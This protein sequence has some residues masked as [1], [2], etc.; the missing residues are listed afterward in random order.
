LLLRSE[1]VAGDAGGLDAFLLTPAAMTELLLFD[2][3]GK[4]E[5][6]EAA[7]HMS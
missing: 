2:E 5:F 7:A 6:S 3:R 4:G 1:A